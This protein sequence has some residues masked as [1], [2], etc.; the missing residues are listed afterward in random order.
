MPRT[1][2]L[3]FFVLLAGASGCG[4]RFQSR[5]A[6]VAGLEASAPPPMGATME[7]KAA[8]GTLPDS[9]AVQAR[10]VIRR[11]DAVLRVDQVKDAAKQVLDIVKKHKGFVQSSSEQF[12]T[13]SPIMTME[14]RVP[15]ESLDVFLTELEKVGTLL[16]RS[17]NSEDVTM[18]VVDVEARLKSM[19]LEEE[20]YRRILLQAKKIPDVLQV[21]QRLTE[22]RGQIESLQAQYNVLREQVAYSTVNIT[23]QQSAAFESELQDKGWLGE[24]WASAV[25][26]LKAGGRATV[27]ALIW[28]LILSPFWLVPLLFF[29]WL[30]KKLT[31]ASRAKPAAVPPVVQPVGRPAGKSDQQPGG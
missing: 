22:I 23:L 15:A 31:K 9:L 18:Q 14:V 10:S 29:W 13:N 25:K 4:E 19:R 28:L 2:W 26:A 16:S 21:Q 8:G 3:L 7:A 11:G 17:T 1:Y 24:T 5:N 27:A 12:V 30:I 6:G 20:A